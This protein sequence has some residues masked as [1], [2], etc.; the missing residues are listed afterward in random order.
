MLDAVLFKVMD[1][2]ADTGLK[3]VHD[4]MVVFGLMGQAVFMSRMVVQWIESERAKKS[5]IPIAFW[6]LSII[7]STM[8]LIYGFYKEDP[9]I[10]AGQLFGFIVYVRNLA[11][12]RAHKKSE[13]AI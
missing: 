7:G 3:I 9:V 2:L 6:Y 13:S 8:V 10:I 5:V 4:P 1:S 11:L 12:I